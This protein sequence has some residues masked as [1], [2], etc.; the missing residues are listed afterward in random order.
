MKRLLVALLLCGAL[1]NLS[2]LY[3]QSSSAL[4]RFT[5]STGVGIV[6]TYYKAGEGSKFL[7]LSVKFGIDVSKSFSLGVFGGYSSTTAKPNIFTDGF[8]TYIVNKTKVLGLRA[9]VKREFSDRI[10]GYGG[11]MIGYHHAD[12]K[13]FNNGT[14]ALVIRSAD[15]PTPFDPNVKKGKVTYSAFMGATVSFTKRLNLYAELGYGISIANLGF[16]VRI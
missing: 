5:I 7:P 14:K 8:E 3:A 9:E 1:S 6:P 12:V 10:K 4:S 16:T 13:E 15:A 2:S 11:A